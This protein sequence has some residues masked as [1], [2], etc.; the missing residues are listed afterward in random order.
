MFSSCLIM[1]YTSDR[2]EINWTARERS[3]CIAHEAISG[4]ECAFSLSYRD[5][6]RG[7]V[8]AD[9]SPEEMP[10]GAIGRVYA[11][12]QKMMMQPRRVMKNGGFE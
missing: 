3:R 12:Y 7:C 1:L 9:E 11:S 4:L 6:R 2:Q 8:S 5:E 10:V